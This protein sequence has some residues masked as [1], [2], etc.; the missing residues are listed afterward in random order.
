V[1]KKEHCLPIFCLDIEVLSYEG[2]KIIAMRVRH[3]NGR[4]IAKTFFVKIKQIE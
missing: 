1:P 2:D 4:A 3:V